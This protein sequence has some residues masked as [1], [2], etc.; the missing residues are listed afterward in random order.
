MPTPVNEE[1]RCSH[2]AAHIGALDVT[3]NPKGMPSRHQ[4]E[5]NAV[6]HAAPPDVEVSRNLKEVIVW[7]LV[8]E[9]MRRHPD[10]LWAGQEF[11]E[12]FGPDLIRVAVASPAFEG[13]FADF[14]LSQG[15]TVRFYNR[16]GSFDMI[17]VWQLAVEVRD[18]RDILN[19]LTYD[20]GI[21]DYE[22]GKVPPTS[23]A[24]LCYRVIAGIMAATVLARDTWR[25]VNAVAKPDGQGGVSLRRDLLQAFSSLEV[26]EPRYSSL[27]DM[28]TDSAYANW[29]I[30][31]D[32]KPQACISTDARAYLAAR[33]G[34]DLMPL[35]EATRE[36]GKPGRIAPVIAAVGSSFLP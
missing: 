10:R 22:H 30:T 20:I 1:G 19:H 2:H 26:R 27:P 36:G 13:L 5:E 33:E 35:F 34:L 23:R 6:N 7:R 11:A 9:M 12:P 3:G 18:P 24:A 17:N 25:C 29:V 4:G 14:D 31:R 15:Q 21:T 16:A 28:A 8:S 32:G